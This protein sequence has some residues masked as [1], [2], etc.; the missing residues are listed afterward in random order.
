MASM[1][2]LLGMYSAVTGMPTLRPP[3]NYLGSMWL[4]EASAT[5]TYLYPD[6]G[7]YESPINYPRREARGRG[8]SRGFGD[9]PTVGGE[10][11][12]DRVCSRG[13]LSSW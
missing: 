8:P 10:R 12:C 11:L 1:T 5:C 4:K 3:T 6:T 7:T 9:E 13:F 2:R